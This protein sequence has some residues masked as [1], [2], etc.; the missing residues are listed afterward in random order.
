MWQVTIN[1]FEYEKN[2][3]KTILYFQKH[4]A[5]CTQPHV[6]NHSSHKFWN[7]DGDQN[8]YESKHWIKRVD[9]EK[10]DEK[11]IKIAASSNENDQLPLVEIHRE[12]E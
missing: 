5:Q 1:I 2:V 12:N 8:K 3:K 9:E 7:V 4:P 11:P 10:S 6:C